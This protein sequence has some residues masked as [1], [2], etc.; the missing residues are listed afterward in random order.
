M[1]GNH[2]TGADLGGDAAVVI[3]AAMLSNTNT[4]GRLV[5]V[6]QDKACLLVVEVCACRLGLFEL[7]LQLGC[8]AEQVSELLLE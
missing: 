2:P 8:V 6:C 1:L 3:V 5:L 7:L 4:A